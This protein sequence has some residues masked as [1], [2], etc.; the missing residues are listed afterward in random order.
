MGLKK[1]TSE[2]IGTDLRDHLVRAARRRN[3]APDAEDLAQDALLRVLNE[4][5]RPG[6]PSL[7]ERAMKTLKNAQIDLWRKKGRE[8][9]LLEK[10]AEAAIDRPEIGPDLQRITEVCRE[11]RAVVGEDAMAYA[12]LKTF[13]G[14]TEA[15]VAEL[16]GWDLNRATAARMRLARAKS[17]VIRILKALDEEG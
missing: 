13:F 9:A 10:A 1:T 2:E 12:F 17:R 3:S 4:V 8:R 5:A 16:L 7:G 6:A 14:A 11:I 15:G